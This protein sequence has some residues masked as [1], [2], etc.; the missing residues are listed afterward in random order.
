MIEDS[1]V[2]DPLFERH[3]DRLLT[4]CAKSSKWWKAMSP[5]PGLA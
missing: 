2:F 3:G 5:S 4:S 1:P